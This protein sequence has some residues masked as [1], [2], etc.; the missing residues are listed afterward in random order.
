VSNTSK[1][2]TTE[3]LLSKLAP[4]GTEL[5]TVNITEIEDMKDYITGGFELDGDG[6]IYITGYKMDPFS[7]AIFVLDGETGAY[8]FGTYEDMINGS[9]MTNDGRFVFMRYNAAG[10]TAVQ[11]DAKARSTKPIGMLNDTNTIYNTFSGVGEHDILLNRG[12][13]VYGLQ[14]DTMDETFIF[15]F[16]DCGIEL[17]QSYT[18]TPV[19]DTEFLL[20]NY[21][22]MGGGETGLYRLVYDPDAVPTEKVTLTLGIATPGY[23][24]LTEFA[25]QSFN[26]VTR[27]IKIE[28]IDYA[29]GVT[30]T[31]DLVDALTRLDLDIA[32]GKAPDI[33][34][35]A[36]MDAAKYGGKGVLTDL[37]DFLNNDESINRADLFENV[38]TAVE[39]DGKLYH[40]PTHF[41]IFT[42]FG[43]ES[44]F[45]D[46]SDFSLA[47]VK[48]VTARYPDAEVMTWGNRQAF[49]TAFTSGAMDDYVDW[50]SG[51][52]NF[53][54]E[55]FYDILR[56]A[57]TLPE[58]ATTPDLSSGEKQA[59]YRE[60]FMSM[61]IENRSLLNIG[62]A[63]TA[64]SLREME[65]LYGGDVAVLG[66]PRPNG[67]SQPAIRPACD[68]G[69]SAS[70]EH[71]EEAWKFISMMM[72][73]TSAS[74]AWTSF[75]TGQPTSINR[76]VITQQLADEMIPVVER[77]FESGY[78]ILWVN[79]SPATEAIVYASPEEVDLARFANFHLTQ[80]EA[81][82]VL[83]TIESASFIYAGDA[84][85]RT[86]MLEEADAFF[87]DVRSVEETARIIQSRV[88]LYV[89]EQS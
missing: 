67:T 14:F 84:S 16:A 37:T 28:I 4:D 78:V 25:V 11:I 59:L 20:A 21:F 47:K 8:I 68:Y 89:A 82:A 63:H 74:A 19:S 9:V 87:N 64:R 18:M 79:P 52:C 81:D 57:K 69:I 43:K 85:I 2:Y 55:T 80:E 33:I 30:S 36:Q 26:R 62:D 32:Q 29:A 70:S 46:G 75:Y 49:I 50:T 31:D 83:A 45:G 22:F 73:G 66:F 76:S 5:F 40:I 6:N 60:E 65:V 86:I 17:G 34:C 48:D 58:E 3:T 61:F 41:D 15:N 27:N 44:L 39:T 88:S 51:T 7:Y 10:M 38:L 13:S 77:S 35:F 23:G 42:P 54:N 1:G 12:G 72:D 56:I 24:I 53:E 71:K